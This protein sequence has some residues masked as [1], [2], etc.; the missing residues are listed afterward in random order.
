MLFSQFAMNMIKKNNNRLYFVCIVMITIVLLCNMFLQ[1][2]WYLYTVNLLPLIIL[3][4][5]I[6]LEG[7][8]FFNY[9]SLQGGFNLLLLII[10]GRFVDSFLS[11]FLEDIGKHTYVTKVMITIVFVVIYGLLLK[12]LIKW[13]LVVKPGNTD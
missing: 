11:Y 7:I 1:K 6:R 3:T 5:Y 12:K 13:S 4:Y 10:S 8:A 2:S 9:R